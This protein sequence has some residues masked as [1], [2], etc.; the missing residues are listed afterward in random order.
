M[1]RKIITTILCCTMVLG[2]AACGV[3]VKV[4][5]DDTK[6]TGVES[7]EPAIDVPSIDVGDG[8]L[9]PDMEPY[10]YVG[11]YYAESPYYTFYYPDGFSFYG[12]QKPSI[13]LNNY[14]D[15]CH[16]SFVSRHE[17]RG[18]DKE[19]SMQ[20]YIDAFKN[21]YGIEDWYD[22]EEAP[23]IY[24][25]GTHQNLYISAALIVLDN[26]LIYIESASK[27]EE[28]AYAALDMFEIVSAK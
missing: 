19:G 3:S 22:G 9:A 11:E 16:I 13:I 12:I 14:D 18:F 17:D 27:T 1:N 10:T 28:N 8:N 25:Y 15:T 7:N 5:S 20:N 21:V 24:T 23:F 26:D 6:L 4:K 2:L